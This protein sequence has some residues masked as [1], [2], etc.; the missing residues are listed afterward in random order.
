MRND[1]S[2]R[3]SGLDQC[4]Q[5]FVTTNGEKKM[6][7][8]DTLHLQVFAGISRQFEHL[9]CQILHDGGSVHCCGRANTL[10]GVDTCLQETMDTS[11]W[12]LNPSSG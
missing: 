5:L 3:N 2:T 10:L 12:E 1:T 4:V 8:S 6:S 9:S 11:Y 7:W